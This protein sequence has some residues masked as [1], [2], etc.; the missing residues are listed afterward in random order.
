MKKTIIFGHRGYP[1]K[2]TENSLAG[3]RYAVAHGVEGVEFDVQLTRD[4]VPIIMHDEKVD[5]TT[6]G[7]GWVKDY[8]LTQIRKLHLANGEPVP[9]LKELL[10]ILADQPLWIN[11]EFKTSVVHYPGIEKKVLALVKQY[12]F[13]HPLIFSSF[14]YI[15]LKNCQRIDPHQTYCYLVDQKVSDPAAI[16]EENHFAGIH[17]GEFL[18]SEKAITQRIWTVNDLQLARKYFAKGVAGIFTNRFAE[19]MA[20]RDRVQK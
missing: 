19:M 2:F 17:P 12:H 20:L 3:F 1:A 7:H 9:E 6:D 11:L 5:R 4:G 13:V 8:T 14:D 16:I 10:A 15:T 18:P